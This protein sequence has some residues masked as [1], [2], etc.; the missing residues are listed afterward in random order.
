MPPVIPTPILPL[1]IDLLQFALN[2][3]HME[4]DFFLFASLGRGL[5]SIAPELAMGGPPPI[6]ARKANLDDTTRLIIEEFGY[7]EVGHLR[8]PSLSFFLCKLAP[9]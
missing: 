5:D 6:G 1:D 2:L 4:A 3:E 7:Q 9:K 8:S